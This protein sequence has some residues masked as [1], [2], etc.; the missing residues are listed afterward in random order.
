MEVLFGN[1]SLSLATKSVS[2]AFE[3]TSSYRET[4]PGTAVG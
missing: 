3:Q 1:T 2:V 4:L